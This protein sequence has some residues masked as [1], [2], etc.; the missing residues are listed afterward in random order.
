MVAYTILIF[1]PNID[2]SIGYI[3]T[4]K[5]PLPPY[6]A[7][8]VETFLSGG[9]CIGRCYLDDGQMVSVSVNLLEP[10]ELVLAGPVIPFLLRTQVRTR[11]L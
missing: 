11:T 9:S 10:S 8:D 4:T 6:Y 5:S 3:Y 2:T 7:S 1:Q